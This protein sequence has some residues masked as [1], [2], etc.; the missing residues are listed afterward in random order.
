MMPEEEKG[1]A[2]TSPRQQSKK[3]KPSLRR[4][5]NPCHVALMTD[6]NENKGK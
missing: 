4:R 2:T 1:K 3:F 6:S 5:L